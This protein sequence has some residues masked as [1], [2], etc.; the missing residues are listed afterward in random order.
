MIVIL[1]KIDFDNFVCSDL[2]PFKILYFE[3]HTEL[4]PPVVGNRYF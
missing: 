3:S 1:N 2:G 4:P